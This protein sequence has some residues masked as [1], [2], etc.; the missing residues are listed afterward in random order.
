M[1]FS[2]RFLSFPYLETM[3]V[4]FVFPS[5]I[6]SLLQGTVRFGA[7]TVSPIVPY[8]LDIQNDEVAL[9]DA[10]VF[11]LR[12]G[13]PSSSRVRIGGTAFGLEFYAV[14]RVTIVDDDCESRTCTVHAFFLTPLMYICAWKLTMRSS[15][16]CFHTYICTTYK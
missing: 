14:A 1:N 3:T 13:S 9:E 5:A 10:E 4:P 16:L 11:T 15:L 7:G 2:S 8:L 6:A 12:L